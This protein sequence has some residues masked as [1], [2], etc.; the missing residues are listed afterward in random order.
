MNNI[1]AVIITHNEEANIE[2]CILALH[3][4]AA[5]VLI[6]DSKSTDATVQIAEKLGAKV[7]V[8]D[9]LGYSKTKNHGNQMA[10]H[11][12]ILSIDADEI[13][14]D[15]L[16]IT[17]NQLQLDEGI[18][19]AL[20]RQT[21]FCGQWIKHSG[22]YPEWKVRLFNRKQTKWLGNYVHEYLDYQVNNLQ[23]NKLQGKLFHY[24]Y[25]THEEH[26]ARI[27]KYAKLSALELQSTGKKSNFIKIW[28]S[29]IVRFLKTFFIK[30]AFLDGK[31]GWIISIRN[32]KLVHLKYKLLRELNK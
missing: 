16:A 19:Y 22:W 24:S 1:S 29:P 2:S 18:V 20:D 3:K 26:L 14:S 9:W 28:C 6:I 31:N 27:Q 8:L 13:L 5:E 32:A 10:M 23:V 30:T 11:D 21:N 4:V 25:K 7:V 15:E 12:W 17:I